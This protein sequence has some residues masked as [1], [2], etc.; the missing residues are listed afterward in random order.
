MEKYIDYG[1]CHIFLTEP[2]K[3][4]M[5]KPTEETLPSGKR[6]AFSVMMKRSSSSSGSESGSPPRKKM[7]QKPVP[8]RFDDGEWGCLR[9]YGEGANELQRWHCQH[10]RLIAK[11]KANN[12]SLTSILSNLSK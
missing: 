9:C 12:R 2:K 5:M 10:C 1:I 6:N 3:E 8:I 11:E 4:T 7:N